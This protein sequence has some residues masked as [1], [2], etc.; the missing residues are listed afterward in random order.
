[1][2]WTDSWKWDSYAYSA[3]TL[4]AKSNPKIKLYHIQEFI[5]THLQIKLSHSL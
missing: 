3:I 4:H 1:M 2:F 5:A